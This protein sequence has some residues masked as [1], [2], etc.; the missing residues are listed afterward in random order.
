[1]SREGLDHPDY[2]PT[3]NIL[4]GLD[5]WLQAVLIIRK[6]FLFFEDKISKI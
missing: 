3:K 4:Y 1:M 5:H 6:W 2:T